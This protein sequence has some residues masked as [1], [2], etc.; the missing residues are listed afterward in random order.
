MS[1]I[2]ARA[3]N[4]LGDGIMALPAIR[5]LAALS[6]DF[7]VQ[8]PCFGAEIYRGLRVEAPGPLPEGADLA[9]LFAPS[10]RAAWQA[11]RARR[12]IGVASDFRGPLLT[13]VVIPARHRAQTYARLAETAGA[14]VDGSPALS[15]DGAPSVEVAQGHVGLVP[16]SRSGPCVEWR[17]F[18]EL[19]DR[20]R[21]PVVA[22]GGPGERKRVA[23][24]LPGRDLG[25]VGLSLSDLGRALGRCRVL[26]ANDSGAAHFARALG[27]PTV[28][29]YGSTSPDRT[30]PTGARSVEGPD[31]GCRP[32]YR[33][34]CARRDLACLRIEVDRVGATIEEIYPGSYRG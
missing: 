6:T 4:H 20:L 30:G 10:L 26:V 17:G 29:V 32:C 28:V 34:R 8:A 3:P 21:V 15:F 13:D 2:V 1:R 22:Y 33:K 18:A 11:R 14:R 31:P 24:R 9:V 27:V 25:A 16:V 7:V 5:A 23:E 12:R 19:A